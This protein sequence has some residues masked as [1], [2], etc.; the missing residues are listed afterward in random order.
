MIRG[1]A[2][3]PRPPAH[4]APCSSQRPAS[5]DF[6]FVSPQG[7]VTGQDEAADLGRRFDPYA[8]LPVSVGKPHEPSSGARYNQRARRARILAATRRLLG[9]QGCEEVTVREI[10]RTSGFALQTIYNLVGPRDRAITDAISEYSLFVGRTA[11]RSEGG[12]SLTGVIDM[13]IV[14]AEACPE[15]ARQ[16]NLIMFTPSRHIYYHFRDIQIRGIAKLL[17][18]QQAQGRLFLKTSPRQVAE[19]VVY[20]ATA[21]WIDWADR[22]YPLAVLREKLSSALP[23]LLRG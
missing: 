4:R 3:R 16:C 7:S 21:M 6:S 1:E 9:E 8:P 12:P 5:E 13:W 18:N 11:A 22:Q 2:S 20:F 17:R 10:A 19:E 15:F 23:K 14:A